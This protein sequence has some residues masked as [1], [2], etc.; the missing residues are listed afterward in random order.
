M[1]CILG[2]WDLLEFL[3]LFNGNLQFLAQPKWLA[4]RM[5]WEIDKNFMS[6]H[7]VSQGKLWRWRKYTELSP[8]TITYT[9]GWLLWD[10]FTVSLHRPDGRHSPSRLCKETV[11]DLWKPIKTPTSHVGPECVMTQAIPTYIFLD[12]LIKKKDDA[13]LLKAMSRTPLTVLLPP[14]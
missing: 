9:C 5:C 3:S 11:S 10:S 8:V 1:Q 6:G 4:K 13:S 7:V 14:G 2:W 12:E